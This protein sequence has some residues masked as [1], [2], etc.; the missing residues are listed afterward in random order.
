[1]AAAESSGAWQLPDL[2]HTAKDYGEICLRLVCSRPQFLE[3]ILIY[4]SR[5]TSPPALR[6]GQQSLPSGLAASVI[7]LRRLL[8]H[9]TASRPWFWDPVER[10][11]DDDV[12]RERRGQAAA[13]DGKNCILQ[14]AWRDFP[15]WPPGRE[16][17]REEKMVADEQQRLLGVVGRMGL[18]SLSFKDIMENPRMEGTFWAREPLVLARYRHVDGEGQARSVQLPGRPS[19]VT[20]SGEGDLGGWVGARYGSLSVHA[21]RGVDGFVWPPQR[22]LG[23]GAQRKRR[24][25]QMGVFPLGN[26][27]AACQC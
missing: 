14:F 10:D 17:T 12:A 8:V 24:G 3:P 1:M 18:A 19:L 11:G 26:C 13:L 2:R 5:I 20:W 16:G 9:L 6:P 7:V 4:Q 22:H 21:H 25:G 27:Q 15:T 23:A